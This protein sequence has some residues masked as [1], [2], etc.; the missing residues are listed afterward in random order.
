MM[1]NVSKLFPQR[2]HACLP[3][4]NKWQ[5]NADNTELQKENMSGTYFISFP[6]IGLKGYKN[7]FAAETTSCQFKLPYQ[8]V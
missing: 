6:E 1:K 2:E 3:L 8:H 4:G 7:W 5:L